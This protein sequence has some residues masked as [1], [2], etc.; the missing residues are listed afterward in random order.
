VSQLTGICAGILADGEVN[1]TK[2]AFFADWVRKVAPLEPTWPF[3]DVLARVDRIFADGRCDDEE[4]DELRDVMKA[5]CGYTD[6]S[7]PEETRSSTLPVDSPLPDPIEFPGRTFNITGK[8]AFGTRRKVMEAI[9]TRGGIPSD[10]AP[11]LGSHYLVIGVFASRDWIESTHGRKI[12]R[13]VELRKSRSGIAI[14]PEEHWKKF[15]V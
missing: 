4:R 11:G 12:E 13:A 10:T 1:P 5:L 2:A 3:T 15:V 7:A 6:E 8:F 14:V 9:A